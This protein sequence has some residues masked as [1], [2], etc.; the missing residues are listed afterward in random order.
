MQQMPT[1]LGKGGKKILQAIA[2]IRDQGDEP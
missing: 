2:A 1:Q